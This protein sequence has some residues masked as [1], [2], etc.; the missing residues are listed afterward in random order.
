MKGLPPK[1]IQDK[2]TNTET[3]SNSQLD[4]NPIAEPNIETGIS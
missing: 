4:K 3:V 2:N 1:A